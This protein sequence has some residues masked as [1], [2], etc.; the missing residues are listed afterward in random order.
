MSRS[1]FVLFLLLAL[2]FSFSPVFAQTVFPTDRA[3]LEQQL[4]EV[5]EQIAQ[6]ESTAATYRKEGK[7][8]QSEIGRIDANIR[9]T[10]LQIRAIEEAIRQ[11]DIDIVENKKKVLDTEERLRFEHHAL[12][13]ILARLNEE[14]Q[15]SSLVILLLMRVQLSEFFGGLVDLLAMQDNLRSTAAAVAALRDELRSEQDDLAAQR[16]ES[17]ALRAYHDAQKVSL[18]RGKKNKNELLLA[19]KGQE[20]KYNE[21]LVAS[22]KT[23]TQIRSQIFEFLGGGELNFSDAY[24][25][26]KT[27]SLATGVRPALIL[28][29]LDRESALGQNVGRCNYRT[30]MHPQRDTPIFLALTTNLNI[31]P[32]S[33]MVSCANRDGAYGGAMGPGQFIPSTWKIFASRI[34]ELTGNNPPSPW[35][36]GDAFMATALFLR[37]AGASGGAGITAERRAAARY[38]AGSRFE[39]YLWTY[40]DRVISKAR[41][42]ERDIA[43]LSG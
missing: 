30:A 22:R 25:L 12:T 21:L 43:V 38:Y 16:T 24:Q 34:A 19:T 29:V 2:T 40:G 4:A 3:L 27:A 9:K 42:F 7:G 28:A 15:Q 14:G 13:R 10:N 18:Q 36:N 1:R 8:L 23:A 31:N 17:L 6:Y 11:L 41:E 39:R 37:D 35:R 5:E 20:S 26:A 32:D 33:V